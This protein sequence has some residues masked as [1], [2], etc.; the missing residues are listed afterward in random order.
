MRP[1]RPRLDTW[2]IV[3]AVPEEESL[4]YLLRGRKHQFITEAELEAILAVY[5]DTPA[6][7]FAMND[8]DIVAENLQY[9]FWRMP[10]YDA[11][12]R[13]EIAVELVAWVRSLRPSR[14]PPEEAEDEPAKL[15]LLAWAQDT[16][17]VTGSISGHSKVICRKLDVTGNIGGVLA[18]CLEEGEVTGNIGKV[19]IFAPKDV[20]IHRSGSIGQC[21]V[22]PCTYEQLLELATKWR[23]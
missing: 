15:Q 12:R 9:A 22:V 3:T 8:P 18:I 1:G 7:P 2:G 17:T 11:E 13:F 5:A 4:S 21:D 19:T 23:R 20:V 14:F 16:L 10:G 6:V